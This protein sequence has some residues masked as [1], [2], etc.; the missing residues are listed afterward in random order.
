MI[1][2]AAPG[3]ALLIASAI[4][5]EA[6]TRIDVVS[7]CAATGYL[8]V[9][10]GVAWSCVRHDVR[11]LVYWNG[12]ELMAML[13]FSVS[14]IVSLWQGLTGLPIV[15]RVVMDVVLVGFLDGLAVFVAPRLGWSCRELRRQFLERTPES[16]RLRQ[17]D[18]TV[19]TPFCEPSTWLNCALAGATVF[20]LLLSL[21]LPGPFALTSFVPF[22]VVPIANW[23][24]A[25]ARKRTEQM[26]ARSVHR[27]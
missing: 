24:L 14:A 18:E 15:E 20:L 3:Y 21:R 1:V 23:H 4:L 19:L 11:L 12:T 17:L 10:F 6:G 9:L 8:G 26:R 7:V 16:Q 2:A 27:S 22:F 25:T 5:R 13:T